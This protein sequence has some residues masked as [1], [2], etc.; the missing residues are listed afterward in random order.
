MPRTIRADHGDAAETETVP[1]SQFDLR[2]EAADLHE[3]LRVI[4]VLAGV[5]ESY[6]KVE[7]SPARIDLAPRHHRTWCGGTLVAS[8]WPGR[9]AAV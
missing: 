2:V 1:A 3:L 4:Y 7:V 9:E 6:R 5:S 8:S